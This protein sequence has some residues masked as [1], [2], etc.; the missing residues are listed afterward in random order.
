[1]HIALCWGLGAALGV[2]GVGVA[3]G[4]AAGLVAWFTLWPAPGLWRSVAAA[5]ILSVAVNV[6]AFGPAIAVS[7]LL[8]DGIGRALVAVVVGSG[9]FWVLL[10]RL[11]A[12][13]SAQIARQ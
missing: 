8:P 11:R 13:S 5:A 2:P 10:Q 4:V 7:L 1:V 6:L 12:Q 3:A 9:L